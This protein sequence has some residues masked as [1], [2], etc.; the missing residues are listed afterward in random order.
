MSKMTLW[1]LKLKKGQSLY[2]IHSTIVINVDCIE[3]DIGA[4]CYSGGE[5]LQQGKN[6]R[7]SS[8]I[9]LG[10]ECRWFGED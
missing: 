8:N 2:E 3:M 1:Q 9:W 5:E 4:R 10:A 7:K 6:D